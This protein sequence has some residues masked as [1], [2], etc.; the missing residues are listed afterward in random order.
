[1]KLGIRTIPDKN[2]NLRSERVRIRHGPRGD[3]RRLSPIMYPSTERIYR[4]NHNKRLMKSDYKGITMA[5]RPAT[6]HSDTIS[7]AINALSFER[8]SAFRYFLQIISEKSLP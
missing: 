7:D 8:P 1:M 3:K 2:P 4:R 6:S 5:K